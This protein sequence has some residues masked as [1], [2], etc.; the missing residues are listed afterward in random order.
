MIV[1]ATIEV[2]LIETSID[3]IRL[4]S[5]RNHKIAIQMEIITPKRKIAF[6]KKFNV[7]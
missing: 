5:D 2:T 1:T 7:F 3:L 4:L 6:P